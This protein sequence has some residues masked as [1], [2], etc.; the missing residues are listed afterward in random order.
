MKLHLNELG[1][2]PSDYPRAFFRVEDYKTGRRI[3][4]FT[5]RAE[6]ENAAFSRSTGLRFDHKIAEMRLVG[7]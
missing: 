2:I 6:A 5:S 1:M 7:R 3:A 4:D